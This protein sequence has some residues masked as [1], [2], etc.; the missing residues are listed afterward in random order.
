MSGT[1]RAVVERQVRRVRRR[2]FW[3][4]LM[5]SLLTGWSAALLLIAGWFLL[6]PFAFAGFGEMAPWA[7]PAVL[8]GVGTLAGF[9]LA[10]L[11]AP[12]RI[13]A[14][15][16][17]DERFGLRE[18]VTTLLLLKPEQA[19]SP[20][21][22]ALLEDAGTRVGGLKVSERFPLALPWRTALP[23]LG[24]LSVALAA[25]FA[26]PYLSNLHLGFTSN[27][28]A[29]H[30]D[31]KEIQE[32]LD[33]I[34]K[35]SALTPK[36]ADEPKTEQLKELEAEWDKLINRSLDLKDPEKLRERVNELRNLEEKLKERFDSQKEK[37][38]KTDQLKK[39]LERLG[40]GDRKMQDGPAKDFQDALVKGQFG[41]AKDV[42]DKLKKQLNK[43]G[44]TKEQ[45]K[46]LAQEFK[47]I[48]E[49]LQRLMDENEQ[50]KQFQKDAA[51]GKISPE[52][53][54]RAMEQFKDMQ[55]MNDV[56]KDLARGLG[57]GDGRAA[58]K[59][60]GKLMKNLGD[61]ELSEEELKELAKCDGDIKAALKVLLKACANCNCNGLNPGEM[62]GAQRPIDP[63]DPDSKIK[64]ERQK[65]EVEL[66]GQQRVTGFVRGGSFSKIP[67]RAVEGAFQQAV[68]SA[69]EAID[70]QR[71]PDDAAD[72][73]RGYFRKLGNQKD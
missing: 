21:G 72:I 18:R 32:Q 23:G 27:Q 65:A 13:S 47:Q 37:A 9:V 36:N 67:A 42:L 35:V 43:E 19:D 2:L 22:Q 61:I 39:E 16:A 1:A 25:Y 51:E 54:E 11:R 53:L 40:G 6:L 48:Q 7:V 28:V 66:R 24:A 73:A 15:L 4:T 29:Q 60:L 68:Q 5:R 70:R 8:L 57:R 44:L 59:A 63:N 46:Q 31:P 17:L 50:L 69:P 58:D 62:P 30:Y 64:N 12:H 52:E 41:K 45:Q 38:E 33:N 56:L 26:A 49:K 3:Q 34:R 71:I 55:E 20:V 10:W 14:A